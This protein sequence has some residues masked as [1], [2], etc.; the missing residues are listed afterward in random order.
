MKYYLIFL[1]LSQTL[2]TVKLDTAVHPVQFRQYSACVEAGEA[3]LAV[4]KNP[5]DFYICR[6]FKNETRGS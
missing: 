1:T 6:G 5:N 2:G 3:H 4:N